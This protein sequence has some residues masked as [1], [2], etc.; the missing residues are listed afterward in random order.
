[1]AVLLD[2]PQIGR[3]SRRYYIEASYWATKKAANEALSLSGASGDK[4]ELEINETTAT[5][6]AA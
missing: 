2:I 3:V 6:D 4:P 1:M 5:F